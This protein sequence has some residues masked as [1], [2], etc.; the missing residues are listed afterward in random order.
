M[1]MEQQSSCSDLLSF[2]SFLK[3][4]T[5]P[6][7]DLIGGQGLLAFSDNLTKSRAARPGGS[8][9]YLEILTLLAV[10]QAE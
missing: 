2:L 5:S 1:P 6:V 8:F 4:A 10:L 3:K 7:P 9:G